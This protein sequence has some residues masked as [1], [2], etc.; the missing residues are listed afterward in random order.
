MK[1]L[2]CPVK[3][4][5]GFLL[6]LTSGWLPSAAAVKIGNVTLTGTVARE[7]DKHLAGSTAKGVSSVFKV[8]NNLKVEQSG[9]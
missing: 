2:S 4:I 1:N 5:V 9:S 6:L 8:T 7:A 3:T